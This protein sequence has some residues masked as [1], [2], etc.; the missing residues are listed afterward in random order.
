MAHRVGL[1]GLRQAEAF[2]DIFNQMPNTE[3]VGL[4]DIDRELLQRVGE[5]AGV[6]KVHP[7]RF[8]HTFAV[9]FLLNR[10]NVFALQRILGHTSLEMV[11]RYLAIAQAD[12][13]QAHREASPVAN[14]LL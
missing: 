13:E 11:N 4:C 5:R 2:I 7:H 14:W 12:I 9:N 8:R 10:G 3:V 1:V 6:R